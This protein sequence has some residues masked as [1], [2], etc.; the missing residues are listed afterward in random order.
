MANTGALPGHRRHAS[1]SAQAMQRGAR[2]PESLHRLLV[3]LGDTVE[4][5]HLLLLGVPAQAH[6]ADV[7][8]GKR[9]GES[10]ERVDVEGDAR[11]RDFA[12][13]AVEDRRDRNPERVRGDRFLA[14]DG[15]PC[16]PAGFLDV[17]ADL[18]EVETVELSLRFG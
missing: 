11:V 16:D 6:R 5:V 15:P 14:D 17:E 7:V 12:E 1:R 2:R 3:G 18:L 4:L 8:I 10:Q 13:A 9:V